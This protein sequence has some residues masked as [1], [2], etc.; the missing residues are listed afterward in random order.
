MGRC[1][2][3]SRKT[4]SRL[5]KQTKP[6]FLFLFQRCTLPS[7]TPNFQEKVDVFA[8]KIDLDTWQ[9]DD[10][11]S[12]PE[13]TPTSQQSQ[14]SQGPSLGGKFFSMLQTLSGNK[15]LTSEDLAPLL[16]QFK[17]H[18]ISKNVASDIAL[19]LC[20]SVS[21]SLEGKKLGTFGSVKT[22]IKNALE[23]SLVRILTPKKSIDI[24]R[25]AQ[26]AKEKGKVYTIVFCGVNGVGKST[27]LA[28]VGNFVEISLSD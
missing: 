11:E 10:P 25:D 13:D 12:D 19:K 3:Q 7:F 6:R 22:T 27:N 4:S 2:Q 16:L 15:P 8:T 21:I 5:F 24:I 28:K 17:D 1:H 23:E 26:E 14:Q 20:D 9:D 18:L